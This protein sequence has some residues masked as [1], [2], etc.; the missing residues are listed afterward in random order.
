MLLTRSLPFL[1]ELQQPKELLE[2]GPM[3]IEIRE[4][5]ETPYIYIFFSWLTW[6][7]VKLAGMYDDSI[8]QHGSLGSHLWM[9]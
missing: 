8:V 3:P 6:L 1:A 5:E 7:A 2:Q 9:T 4:T